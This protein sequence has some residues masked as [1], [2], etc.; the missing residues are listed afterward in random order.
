MDI[1]TPDI[2]MGLKRKNSHE[3]IKLN[4]STF[5]EDSS[6]SESFYSMSPYFSVGYRLSK[7]LILNFDVGIN[8]Y[9][10]NFNYKETEHNW[11]TDNT[12]LKTYP[13]NKW[14]AG[15]NFGLGFWVVIWH[16]K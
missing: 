5:D 2:T 12:V 15:V 11:L 16:R 3:I 4:Y 13:Y 10:V 8:A 9:K 1:T 14:V 6:S 7:R